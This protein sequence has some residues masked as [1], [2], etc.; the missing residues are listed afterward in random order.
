LEPLPHVLDR[1]GMKGLYQMVWACE[2]DPNCQKIIRSSH[3][4]NARPCWIHSDIT[5]RKPDHIP[6][7]DLYVAGFP[8]QPFSTMGLREGV[9]DR[10]GRG[11]IV[12]H[13]LA[14]LREKMPRAFILENVQGLVLQH[15]ETFRRI[16]DQLQTMHNRLYVVGWKVLNTE[17]HGIPQ[18]RKRVYIIGVRKDFYQKRT[19]FR[20]PGQIKPKPLR[21]FLDKDMPLTRVEQIRRVREFVKGSPRGIRRKLM[22]AW[23][24]ARGNGIAV[25]GPANPVIMDVDSTW[26]SYMVGRC[27]CITRSRGSSRFFLAPR[28]RRLSVAEILRLQG[29]P[30]S[31][32][33]HRCNISDRQLGAMVGN[34][35]S[36]NV[37]ERILV[38]LLPACGFAR[39]SL[40]DPWCP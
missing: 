7:H 14:G 19:P 16:I 34:A 26:C 1:I 27:P 22:S 21:T 12:D 23:S 38:R 5:V 4:G 40:R 3:T 31:I 25:L 2:R 11:T 24:R 29:L 6:D 37:L 32:L 10:L 13:V 30:T 28:G 39:A 35:M 15:W 18:H 17:H 36:G 9:Q 8:C 33:R 20:W